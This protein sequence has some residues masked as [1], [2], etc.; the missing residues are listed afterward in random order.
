MDSENRLDSQV[1]LWILAVLLDSDYILQCIC[2]IWQ[3]IRALQCTRYS[4]QQQV[5]VQICYP[6]N[7]LSGHVN[8]NMN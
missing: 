2:K 6:I 3:V 1:S 5:C 8:I 4:V 7:I